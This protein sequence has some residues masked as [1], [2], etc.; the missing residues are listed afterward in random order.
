MT[1]LKLMLKLNSKYQFTA[2]K[3]IFH[4]LVNVLESRNVSKLAAV[5]RV[6]QQHK[7][8]KLKTIII[9]DTL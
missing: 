9:S 5:L 6:L 1:I 7:I 2:L 4:K 8:S 3:Q